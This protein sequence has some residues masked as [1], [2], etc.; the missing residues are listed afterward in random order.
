MQT[1]L[2]TNNNTFRTHTSFETSAN[3]CQ[4][5]ARQRGIFGGQSVI[6]IGFTP[7]TSGFPS[8]RI[9]PPTPHNA[10]IASRRR[11]AISTINSV[12]NNTFKRTTSYSR[13]SESS[14]AL[15]WGPYTS[16]RMRFL[17]TKCL[18][19]REFNY[20]SHSS[21]ITSPTTS[22]IHSQF[23]C[24]VSVALIKRYWNTNYKKT[25]E[26]LYVHIQV[27][28]FPWKPEEVP[29]RLAFYAAACMTRQCSDLFLYKFLVSALR[30]CVIVIEE[31][32]TTEVDTN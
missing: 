17:Y 7:G 14:S 4:S 31:G 11:D 6:V 28:C 32:A 12:A 22:L 2:C 5:Q 23:V 21:F 27:F 15:L 1:F 25:K 30:W 20:D 8:V 18:F 26:G 16:Q 10:S 19:H 13:R 29:L 24:A 3:I 9:I